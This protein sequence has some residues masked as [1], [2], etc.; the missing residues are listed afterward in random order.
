MPLAGAAGPGGGLGAGGRGYY[1]LDITDPMSPKALW[2]FTNDS[3]GIVTVASNPAGGS[4]V[5]IWRPRVRDRD[6]SFNKLGR[7]R[8]P[9]PQTQAALD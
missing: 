1:A 4:D 9:A 6:R 7:T 2:E 8:H 3:L 5:L